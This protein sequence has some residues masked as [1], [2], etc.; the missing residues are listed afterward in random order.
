MHKE[1]LVY[2]SD[3]GDVF[4]AEWSRFVDHGQLIEVQFQAQIYP[5][6]KIAFV[7]KNLDPEAVSAIVK[8]G[9][10]MKVVTSDVDQIITNQ[11]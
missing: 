3:K 4:I 7:Y 1:D 10:G 6:G 9:Y 2:Y 5:S 11:S 8:S